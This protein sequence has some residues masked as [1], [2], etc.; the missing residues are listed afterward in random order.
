ME[1]INVRLLPKSTIESVLE[2]LTKTPAGTYPEPHHGYIVALNSYATLK[3][4]LNEH[5][6]NP[7]RP[8]Q[9][10]REGGF[11]G[12]W[13]NPAGE[14]M[15]EFCIKSDQIG[16]AKLLGYRNSQYSIW[17]V[18]NQCEIVLKSPNGQIVPMGYDTF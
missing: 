8:E 3:Q 17:D 2:K 13:T 14:K 11:I 18:K 1:S 7:E 6:S 5:I 10:F 16:Q 4:C 15:Y 9:N 12:W